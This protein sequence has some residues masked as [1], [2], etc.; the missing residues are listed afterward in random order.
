[1]KNILNEKPT[2]DLNG[3]ILRISRFMSTK[4]IFEKRIL[5]IGCGFGWCEINLL[6]RGA[7]QVVG[8]DNDNN[9]L[10]KLRR[11]IKNKKAFFCYG[12][13]LKLPFKDNVFDTVVS[14]DV[15]EHISKGTEI[16]M[17]REVNRVLK[18]KGVFYLS[19]PHG[20]FFSTMLDPAWWLIRHRHYVKKDIHY[21]GKTT[22]FEIKD[23]QISGGWWSILHLWLMYFSKWI[24]HRETIFNSYLNRLVNQEY[25]KKGFETIFVRLVKK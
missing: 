18:S 20:S 3:R 11:Y 12:T 17:F 24:L 5:D 9:N 2:T 16:N 23:I 14:W 25:R 6:A 19:T 13:A 22:G 10:K 1:M 8:L 15:I 21:F 4:H 7:K